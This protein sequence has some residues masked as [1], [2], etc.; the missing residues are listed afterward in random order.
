MIDVFCVENYQLTV[1][2]PRNTF[3]PSGF[4]INLIWWNDSLILLNNTPIRYKDLTIPCCKRCN[5]IMSNKIE[6]PIQHFVDGGYEAFVECNREIAFQW[7][8]KISYGIL[9][10]ELSLK[11]D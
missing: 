9:F 6:K 10:E 8:T 11:F 4:R 7:L 3:I 2:A 1:I 5:G